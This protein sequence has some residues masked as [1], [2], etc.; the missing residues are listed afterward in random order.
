LPELICVDTN[1]CASPRYV[2][3]MSR[4]EPAAAA[5]HITTTLTISH[6]LLANMAR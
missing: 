4:I 3:V 6:A 1:N 5:R 2:G